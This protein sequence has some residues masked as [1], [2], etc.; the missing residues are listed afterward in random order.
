[1]RKEERNFVEERMG[2]LR[3]GPAGID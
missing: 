1:M 3:Q 2:K